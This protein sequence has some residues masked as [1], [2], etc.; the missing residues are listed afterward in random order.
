MQGNQLHWLACSL[1]HTCWQASVDTVQ[2]RGNSNNDAAA[3]AA[4]NPETEDTQLVCRG[5]G[6]SL[7]NILR[8]CEIE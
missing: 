2:N 6:V 4:E 1:T 5:G 8:K 7:N 3:A